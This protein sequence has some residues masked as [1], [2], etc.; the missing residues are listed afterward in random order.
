M[1][2]SSIPFVPA[3]APLADLSSAY[4]ILPSPYQH[5]ILLQPTNEPELHISNAHFVPM[6][7]L[8]I[9]HDVLPYVLYCP[10]QGPSLSSK[11]IGTIAPAYCACNSEPAEEAKT[12]AEGELLN[13]EQNITFKTTPPRMVLKILEGK[14]DLVI[15]AA[16]KTYIP[17]RVKRRDRRTGDLIVSTMIGVSKNGRKW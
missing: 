7:A 14:E 3:T 2:Q 4:F 11:S 13:V 1:N 17:H 5:T 10:P 8:E 6:P 12:E 9:S 15:K 16:T